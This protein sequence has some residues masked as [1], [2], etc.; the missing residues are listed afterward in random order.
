M[1]EGD[2]F[3]VDAFLRE[4]AYFAVFGFDHSSTAGLDDVGNT[5]HQGGFARSVVSSKGNA[6]F[7]KHSEGQV[8]KKNPGSVFHM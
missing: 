4:I 2:A 7:R 1:P 5:L 3:D 8:I 6:L